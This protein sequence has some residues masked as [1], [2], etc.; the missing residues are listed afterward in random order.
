VD[1][2]WKPERRCTHSFRQPNAAH[3]AATGDDELLS[4]LSVL[5]ALDVTT[6]EAIF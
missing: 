3:A 6:V 2:T 4:L 1:V 5:A